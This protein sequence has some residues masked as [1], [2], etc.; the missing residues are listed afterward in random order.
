MVENV[1]EELK[2][3]FRDKLSQKWQEI[4]KQAPSQSVR[5]EFLIKHLVWEAQAKEKGGYTLQAKK[6]LNH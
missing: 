3:L 4:F 2:S 6:N 1:I 5:S